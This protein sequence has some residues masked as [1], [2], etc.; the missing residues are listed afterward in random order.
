MTTTNLFVIANVKQLW[1]NGSFRILLPFIWTSRSVG[2]LNSAIFKFSQSGW[3][4]H[5]FGGPSEFRRG[6][7]V[8]T[9]QTSPSRY[10]TVQNYT[11]TQNTHRV[12]NWWH[13]GAISDVLLQ[14][15]QQPDQSVRRYWLHSTKCFKFCSFTAQILKLVFRNHRFCW[16]VGILICNIYHKKLYTTLQFISI[17]LGLYSHILYAIPNSVVT[18]KSSVFSSTT[19]IERLNLWYVFV[20]I[21][22]STLSFSNTGTSFR[23]TFLNLV[24]VVVHDTS[25]IKT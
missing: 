9:P 24:L 12:C 8:W 3:V 23:S 7:G 2:I 19:S 4:W 16:N 15:V 20:S 21:S 17:I 1:T 6:G 5:D 13:S 18:S 14:D 10:A 25:R 22:S 11:P